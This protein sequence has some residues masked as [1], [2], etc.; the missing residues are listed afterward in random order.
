MYESS[1]SLAFGTWSSY[2]VVI[3]VVE[4]THWPL[5][6]YS[7]IERQKISLFQMFSS[8]RYIANLENKKSWEGEKSIYCIVE[9]KMA[10]WYFFSSHDALVWN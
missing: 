6:F 2:V 4:V 1:F 10:E 9:K 5:T 8:L 3:M 7:N